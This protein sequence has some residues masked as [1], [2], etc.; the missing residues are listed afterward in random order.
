M[1][2][3]SRRFP[4]A[5]ILRLISTQENRKTFN[6]IYIST[7]DFKEG[8]VVNGLY[9]VAARNGGKVEFDMAPI[10]ILKG[11]RMVIGVERRGEE[12]I[13]S[14]R[15]VMWKE[16]GEKGSMPLER[17]VPMWLHEIVSWWLLDSGT[18]YLT[19]LGKDYKQ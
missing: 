9:R 16:A 19:E 1:S 3:F 11:G 10:G 13:C 14:S 12:L 5:Y 2:L 6:P 4:Q 8:D 15:V 7:L 18:R 17:A